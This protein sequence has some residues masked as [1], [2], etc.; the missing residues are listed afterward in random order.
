MRS[1]IAGV[2][3]TAIS[4]ISNRRSSPETKFTRS[5]AGA[6]LHIKTS[7]RWTLIVDLILNPDRRCRS[8]R[9]RSVSLPQLLTFA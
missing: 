9:S 6:S 4:T 8:A 1:A 5:T 7:P 2:H 3:E